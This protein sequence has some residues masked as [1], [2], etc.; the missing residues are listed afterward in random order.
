MEIIRPM[1]RII[2]HIHILFRVFLLCNFWVCMVTG[3]AQS[4][5]TLGR[6]F[7]VS[8]MNSRDEGYGI[9]TKLIVTG[10]ENCTGT[11]TNPS[12]GWSTGFTVTAGSITRVNIPLAQAYTTRS[13]QV[14]NT[15]LHVTSTDTI[16]L[17]AS[18]FTTFSFDV[19]N[20]LPTTALRDEYVLQTY[21]GAL[22][23]CEALIVATQNGTTVDI[24]P[25]CATAHGQ[26]AN[27][28]Y[29]VTLDAGQCYQIASVNGGDL[30][31]SQVMARDGRKIAVFCGNVC[32]YIPEG[33]LACDHLVEQDWPVAFW[34]KQFVV[35]TSSMRNKDIVRVTASA[36]NC[37]VKKN[38]STIATLNAG[39]THQFEL[40]ASEDAVFIETTQPACTYLYFTGADYGG[41]NGDPSMV[42]IS[43]IEQQIHETTFGTFSSGSSRYHFVNVVTQTQCVNGMRLDGTDI[44]ERFHVLAANPDYAYAKIQVSDNA[45]R[46]SNRKGGFV[47]HVYGL[48]FCE[49]YAYSVGSNVADLNAFI[50][51]NDIPNYMLPNGTT[52]C[53]DDNIEFSV[54]ANYTYSSANWHF[55]DGATANGATVYHTYGVAGDW[56]AYVVLTR[57]G[58]ARDTL[59]TIVHTY[60]FEEIELTDDVC[61][62]N[63]YTDNGFYISASRIADSL[64]A[65]PGQNTFRFDTITATSGNCDAHKVLDLTVHDALVLNAIVGD[66]TPC[67][68]E[69]VTYSL[70]HVQQGTQY[71]WN[72]P[73]GVTVIGGEQSA[74]LTVSFTNTTPATLTLH[75][76]NDCGTGTLPITVTPTPTY[77]FLFS[78]SLC[79]GN[80]YDAYGFHLPR[81]DSLGMFSFTN[82]YTTA[83]GCDSI[84]VLQL[85]VTGTPTLTTLA[86]P[87]VICNGG[88]TTIHA[89]GDNAS[90]IQGGGGTPPEVAIGDI[91]CT[92]GSIVKPAD[93]PCGRTAKGIVFYVDDT[94]Q[95]GWMVH[96]QNQA[97]GD[98]QWSTEYQDIPSLT[99]YTTVR[100]AITD[101]DG[102][103]NTQKIRNFGNASN[104]PAAWEVDFANGWYLPAAGQLNILYG[105]LV[106]VNAGL[107]AV[108]GTL[109]EMNAYWYYW[110]SS[111]GS[112]FF[113]WRQNHTGGVLCDNK[114]YTYG[115]YTR[116]R[117]VSAF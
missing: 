114:D 86:E 49:S 29:S 91:V 14:V 41:T 7:W 12:T 18:N 32:E 110:S 22:I 4:P 107:A 2:N 90:V 60:Q 76:T 26:P 106:E 11:V 77:H 8:F 89:L 50:E 92:D 28:Q 81:Q 31:G 104:Y 44:S 27:Q 116:V 25:K 23:N 3:W 36:N 24:T 38:G 100:T 45:H 58:N 68:L 95:H 37:Q 6:D 93:W 30:S 111:E 94:G 48:G 1:K 108:G 112:I 73:S 75:G 64:A 16:S 63:D 35:T 33:Y 19:T 66:L 43:P 113:A 54:T 99:N 105:N 52:A 78:D 51:V 53:K 56:L 61:E 96:L 115:H 46:L 65:Y 83:A 74:S 84:R 82:R 13:G 9:E 109:F 71:Y 98:I 62:G 79:S 21:E 80:T 97:T 20:V 40:N 102:Y 39:Q 67:T 117:S 70:A 88:S 34:G 87:A 47:A 85:L 103:G 69:P 5:S 57:P 15:G 42:I 101:F 10:S 72:V 17:Y 59:R 55:G